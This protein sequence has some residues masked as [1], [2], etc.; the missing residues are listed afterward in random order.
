M[1]VRKEVGHEKRSATELRQALA[2]NRE[3]MERDLS[4]LGQRF[5][6]FLNP[7][8]LLSRHPILTAGVGAVIG[9]LIVRRPAQL[10]RAA[11]RLAGLGAPLL[12]SALMKGDGSG[13]P[14]APGPRPTND[15][16]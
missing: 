6:D 9:F 7:R 10:L 11:S 4:E 16:H 2:E 12:L 15:D 14:A 3:Q 5:H 1:S 8:H 13:S